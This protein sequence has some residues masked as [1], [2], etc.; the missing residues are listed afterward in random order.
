MLSDQV[1]Q[2]MI[3]DDLVREHRARGLNPNKPV[4]R[5][6]AQ[7][8]DIFFQARES[9]NKY[10]DACPAIVQ[11]AMDKV[12]QL[13]WA[14]ISFVRLLRRKRRGASACNHGIWRRNRC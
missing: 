13:S 5:G 1:M 3:D 6:T 7:N 4:L 12:A 14:G 8:P 10:Y 11:K 2:D 9:V